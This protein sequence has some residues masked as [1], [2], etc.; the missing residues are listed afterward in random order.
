[1]MDLSSS[2]PYSHR[3]VRV[4]YQTHAIF[5]GKRKTQGDLTKQQVISIISV[6]F[7]WQV[8]AHRLRWAASS[9][10]PAAGRTGRQTGNLV[11]I[12]RQSFSECGILSLK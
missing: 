7:P 2:F 5:W 12:L 1:M 9:Q 3:F 10:Q 11:V 6:F 8:G 4:Y